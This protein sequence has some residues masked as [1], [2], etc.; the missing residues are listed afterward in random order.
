MHSVQPGSPPSTAHLAWSLGGA[1]LPGPMADA[2]S[3]SSDPVRHALQAVRAHFGM[4]VACIVECSGNERVVRHVDCADGALV[5][6]GHR[7]PLEGSYCQ[8]VIDGR[9][10]A[11]L[12]D[13]ARHAHASRLAE[14]RAW[15]IR[16]HLGVPI[17]FSDGEV[18]GAFCCFGGSP[19]ATLNARDAD[20]MRTYADFVAATLEA[21]RRV[22]ETRAQMHAR[23]RRMLDDASYSVVFQ[24]IVD[25]HTLLPVGYEALTRFRADTGVSTQQWFEDAAAVGMVQELEEATIAEALRTLPLLPRGAYLSVNVSPST[26]LRG[27]LRRL[28]ADM[29]LHRIVLEVTEHA[30]VADYEALAAALQ[31]LRDAGLRL[32]VDDAG[33]GF[34]SF[35]HIL[36]MR[37]DDIKLD[38]SLIR[39]IDGDRSARALAAALIQFARDTGSSIVAEGV[40]TESVLRV[41]RELRV[42]KAQG[43]LLG[44]G[45]P[46]PAAAVDAVL[47]DS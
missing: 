1:G 5:Q 4:D 46:L 41:L 25:V 38:I 12:P 47:G 16:S 11:A 14:T 15:G 7:G 9:V 45:A 44:K 6:D 43:F 39:K 23:V 35:R 20:T 36:R 22:K 2:G 29:P 42:Q 34:A 26:V 17:R 8:A 30:A 31:P 40:E 3:G 13:T 28:L 37:P 19:D 27:G 10:P 32:A 18:Y 33:A 21:Q 24:P